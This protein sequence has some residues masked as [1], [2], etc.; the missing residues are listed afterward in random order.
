MRSLSRPCRLAASCQAFARGTLQM[1]PDAARA[2]QLFL[3]RPTFNTNNSQ[4]AENSPT[5]SSV[6]ARLGS[7]HRR[8]PSNDS[9]SSPHRP[10][11]SQESAWGPAAAGP[12]G[13]PAPASLPLYSREASGSSLK[14]QATAAPAIP[15]APSTASSLDADAVYS[16]HK[17]IQA[18][19]NH[20][21][22]LQV[23]GADDAPSNSH[24]SLHA[25]MCLSCTELSIATGSEHHAPAMMVCCPSCTL[26]PL[27]PHFTLGLYSH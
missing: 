4:A 18:S 11:G 17:V 8:L 19:G 14:A 12:H 13:P 24:V 15:A 1:A 27:S 21:T 20:A 22:V 2:E 5:S 16:R 26:S 9:P 3:L 7:L 25:A 6:L 10:A 23:A